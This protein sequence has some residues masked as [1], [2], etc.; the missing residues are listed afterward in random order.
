VNFQPCGYLFLASQ[1]GEEILTDNHKTQTECGADT[2][3]LSQTEL[4][5]TFPWLRTEA[6]EFTPEVTA[7]CYGGD[8]EG[9]FD[10]WAL[11]QA[12]KKSAQYG[13]VE[14]V[15]GSVKNISRD[16]TGQPHTATVSLSGGDTLE[17]GFDSVVIAA[18]G[19][20]GQVGRLFGIGE[21]EGHMAVPIPVEKRKRYVYVPHCPP[22]PGMDCPLVIDPTGVYFRREGLGGSYL[23]GQSPTEEQEPQDTDLDLVDMDWFEDQVWPVMA[24]RVDAFQQLKVRASWAGNYDYNTWDQN[25]I[26]GRHPSLH[27]TFLACGFSGH[28]IQQ[29][30]AVGRAMSELILDGK[31]QS[32]DLT[33]LGLERVIE[34][35]KVLEIGPGIV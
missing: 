30:P 14:Y 10:P 17:I 28:G 23:C 9:W 31:F 6:A 25:G 8:S 19:D 2:V 32:L 18:G 27:N 21:G 11:L 29:G 12:F 1:G 16:S 15:T 33:E 26:V 4:R 20:S 13:G 22:G 24:H 7:G 35:R 34:K 5:T 3:M